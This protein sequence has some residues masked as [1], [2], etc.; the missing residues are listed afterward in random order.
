MP[1]VFGGRS[2]YL[3][4]MDY[5]NR[6]GVILMLIILLYLIYGYVSINFGKSTSI[7]RVIIAAILYVPFILLIKLFIDKYFKEHKSFF[8][9]RKGEYAIYYELLK[10]P[11]KYLV[12]Q[13][14]KINKQEGNID[15]VVIGPAGIFTVEVKSHSG[16]IEFN[17]AELLRNGKPFEK[18]I[19]GQ[20]LSEALNLKDYLT[21]KGIKDV[22]ANP[23]IVFSNKYA[24]VRFGFNKLKNVHVVQKRFLIELILKNNGLLSSENIAS[25]KNILMRIV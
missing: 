18:N 15:F 24:S 25:I 5:I 16:K 14:V 8:H 7:L 19:L 21:E 1:Q 6:I 20:A 22:Y 23:V 12:F 9:G 11:E 17:E 10:L 4:R 2:K 3:I 13:D